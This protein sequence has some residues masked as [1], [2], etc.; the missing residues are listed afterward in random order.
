M[1]RHLSSLLDSEQDR[2]AVAWASAL[3]RMRPSAYVCRPLEELRRLGRAYLAELVA[4]LDS[5]D[6]VRLR[7][8][9]HREAALRFSMGFGAAEVVQGFV[10]FREITRE[11]CEQ[12]VAGG[13][14]RL[15]LFRSLTEATDFTVV[16]FVTFFNHLSEERT[17]AQQ[18]EMQNLQRALVDEAVQDEVT[19]FFTGRYFDEHLAVEVKRAARYHRAFSLVVLDIDDFAGLRDRYGAVG[20]DA[21][22]RSAADALRAL[23]RDVDIKARTDEAEFSIAMPETP[24]EPATAV[25]ERLRLA[26]GKLPVPQDAP[27][28]DWRSL[29]AS[30]GVG[31]HPEHGSTARE[32]LLS[33]R[34]A[35]DRARMLGGDVTLRAESPAQQGARV[36]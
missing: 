24:L 26:V 35:R 18:K 7:E 30:V 1:A 31:S 15:V 8:F 23:T 17:A 22:L 32:L 5:D 27:V 14:D 3:S 10:V 13:E 33:V 6:P 21:T 19:D 9:V 2:I 25:A 16:E 12:L 29:S 28:A 36:H 11:L 4:Y 20:A 34:Q